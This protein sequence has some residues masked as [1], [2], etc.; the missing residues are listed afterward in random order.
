[1]P[2]IQVRNVPE[3][4]HR[5]LQER[6]AKAGMSLREY[7]RAELCRT[8]RLRT[9]GELVGEVERRMAVEGPEGFS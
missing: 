5:T 3:D 9:P 1:M 6:A 4:V 8:A 2:T 7:L